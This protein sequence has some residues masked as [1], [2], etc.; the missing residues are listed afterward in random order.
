MRLTISGTVTPDC[1]IVD[2]GEPAGELNGQPYWQWTGKK[3][4]GS[5]TTY[6]LYWVAPNWIIS[7]LLGAVWA[8]Q[9]ANAAGSVIG[10]YA[11]GSFHTGT[12]TV[13]EY[14]PPEPPMAE[15][16]VVEWTAS[17]RFTVLKKGA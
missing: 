1:T 2:T 6:F 10:D 8:T 14:T 5:P 16:L 4:D 3:P 9:W 13:T 12:V 7:T 15:Y 17:G 11:P